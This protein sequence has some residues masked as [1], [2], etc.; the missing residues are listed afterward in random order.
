MVAI[1]WRTIKQSALVTQKLL[2]KIPCCLPLDKQLTDILRC[3]SLV[4]VSRVGDVSLNSP[5]GNSV[6]NNVIPCLLALSVH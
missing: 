2:C 5:L 3:H 4:A 6:C 1:F